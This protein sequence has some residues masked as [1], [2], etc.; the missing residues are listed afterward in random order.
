MSRLQILQRSI[1]TQFDSNCAM[2]DQSE[3]ENM[4]TIA[5]VKGMK[6]I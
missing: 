5:T 2:Q 3:F 6:N 1:P 4:I